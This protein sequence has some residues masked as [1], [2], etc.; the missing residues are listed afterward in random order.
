MPWGSCSPVDIQFQQVESSPLM[1]DFADSPERF[2]KHFWPHPRGH[3]S[4]SGWGWSPLPTPSKPEDRVIQDRVI[5]DRVIQ[6]RVIQNRGRQESTFQ[7]RS[8]QDRK[9]QETVAFGSSNYS[10]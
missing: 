5:Q 7:D 9:M 6:D 10:A 8:I 1:C 2:F 3:F 4:R